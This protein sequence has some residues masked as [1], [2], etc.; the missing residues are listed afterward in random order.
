MSSGHVDIQCWHCGTEIKGILL[1]F[2][3]FEECASC[4]SDLH[5]CKACKYYAPSLSSSCNEDRA[6]FV[7]EKDQANFCDFFTPHP[8]PFNSADKLKEHDARAKLAELFGDTNDGP[9]NLSCDN[10]IEPI[11]E[12]DK[13]LAELKRL[14]GED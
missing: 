8:K 2:S 3:R 11:S 7:L 12:A 6:D 13:A 1:P 10:S 14:F 4:N 5:T 9:G